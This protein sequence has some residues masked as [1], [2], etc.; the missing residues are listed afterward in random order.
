MPSEPG[1]C[2]SFFEHDSSGPQPRLR[3]QR[4]TLPSME[5]YRRDQLGDLLS[6]VALVRPRHCARS[7]FI[8]AAS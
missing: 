7:S 1:G 2:S 5:P 8:T 4:A 3:V 6:D